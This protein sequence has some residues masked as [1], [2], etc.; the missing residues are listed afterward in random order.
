[1]PQQY[2]KLSEIDMALAIQSLETVGP[3]PESLL[4]FTKFEDLPFSLEPKRMNCIF[5]GLCLEGEVNMIVDTK[6]VQVVA[7]QSIVIGPGHV[8]SDFVVSRNCR[9]LGYIGSR[10]F[11][12]E[13]MKNVS[14]LSTLFLYIREHPVRSCSAKEQEIYRAYFKAIQTRF[15]SATTRFIHPL[16][17]TLIRALVYDF[18][19]LAWSDEAA[20][21]R[22]RTRA[23]NIFNDFVHM[24]EDNFREQRK[25]SWY[26]EQLGI[27]PKYLSE[28]VKAVSKQT[29][30]DWIDKYVVMELRLILRD[31]TMSIKEVTERMCFPN[32]SFLGKYFKEHVGM[33][34]SEYR[35]KSI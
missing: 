15:S 19:G 26:A 17:A 33:S 14:E 22:G 6:E 29:P 25:V 16:V 9:G 31:T 30:N 1:M 12:Q 20:P 3:I 10:E 5:L 4:L 21:K 23:E 35:R 27:S 13:A 7:G 34:P 24:V 28:M 32:Q 11:F 2:K 8:V 18:G